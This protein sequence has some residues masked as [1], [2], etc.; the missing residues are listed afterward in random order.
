M[1][2]L[3][4][5]DNFNDEA[6]LIIAN[7]LFFKAQWKIQFEEGRKKLEYFQTSTDRYQTKIMQV[8]SQFRYRFIEDLDSQALELPYSVSYNALCS[9]TLN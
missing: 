5:T 8:N 3:F 7:A 1:P 9:A 2:L 6:S 4:C